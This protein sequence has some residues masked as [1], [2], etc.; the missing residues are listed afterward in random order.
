MVF[1]FTF[2]NISVISRRLVLYLEETDKLYHIMLYRMHLAINVCI[3]LLFDIIFCTDSKIIH[4]LYFFCTSYFHTPG[5]NGTWSSKRNEKDSE[6]E[7]N[8]LII[9]RYLNLVKSL[10]IIVYQIEYSQIVTTYKMLN[11][12][13]ENIYIM[14]MQT[15]T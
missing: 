2:N 4:F 12:L 1:N 8:F 15:F 9:C 13:W 3:L 10:R 7:Y 5:K 11:R 6:F 14:Y